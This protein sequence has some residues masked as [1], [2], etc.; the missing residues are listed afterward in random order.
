[1]ASINNFSLV[2]IRSRMA[3]T[4]LSFNIDKPCPITKTECSDLDKAFNDTNLNI[5]IMEHNIVVSCLGC[6]MDR[7]EDRIH[8]NAACSAVSSRKKGF[9]SLV[10]LIL[11]CYAKDNKIRYITADTNSKSR[12]LMEKYLNATCSDDYI[13]PFYDNNCIVDSEDTLTKKVVLRNINIIM[14]KNM[15]KSKT[16]RNRSRT[17]S[18][19]DAVRSRSKRSR[20]KRSR[21]NGSRSKG[22]SSKGSRSKGS[23]S[24]G[25]SSK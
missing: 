5:S 7:D 1:M 17:K 24:K 9:G 3:K 14:N 21:S 18:A 13:P 25:S 8:I 12:P 11:F 4:K 2:Y 16:Q 22:S 20:S 23:S 15:S 10:Q 6:I 19:N